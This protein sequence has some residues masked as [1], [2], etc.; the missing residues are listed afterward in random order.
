MSRSRLVLATFNRGK[1]RELEALLTL[2]GLEWVPLSDWPGAVAPLETGAT[3]LENARIKARAAF[4][5]TG[6]AALADD[7]GLEVDALAGAPGVHSARFAGPGATDAENIDR[8]LRELADTP[9]A[10]R[11]ARFRTVCVVA[12]PQRRELV[13]QGVLEGSIARQRRGS[14]GFGYDPVFQLADG[15]MLAELTD[16]QKNAISHRGHAVKALAAQLDEAVV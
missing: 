6:L 9:D 3:L 12:L 14:G 2:P 16:A 4:G 11:T 15:R 13:A 7:T 8:L 1:A 10:A 5:L